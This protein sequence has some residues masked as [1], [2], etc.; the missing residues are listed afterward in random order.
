[1]NKYRSI[2]IKI[3]KRRKTLE[4]L[5]VC[6]TEEL[7]L[8]FGLKNTSC[9]L[10][11]WFFFNFFWQFGTTFSCINTKGWLTTFCFGRSLNQKMFVLRPQWSL[12]GAVW[13]IIQNKHAHMKPNSFTYYTEKLAHIQV[14][15]FYIHNWNTHTNNWKIIRSHTQLKSLHKT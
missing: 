13:D 15:S 7:S 5:I 2:R 1:M 11:S 10:I 8:L 14:K 9:A 6:I 12:W 4:K 3:K